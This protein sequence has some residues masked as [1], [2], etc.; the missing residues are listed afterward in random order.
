[1][2]VDVDEDFLYVTNSLR[3]MDV[4]YVLGA[5]DF[6]KNNEIA[7]ILCIGTAHTSTITKDLEKHNLLESKKIQNYK[8]YSLTDKGKDMLKKLKDYHGIE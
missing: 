6:A 8:I 5:V 1:M 3:R 2:S 7:D 4:M